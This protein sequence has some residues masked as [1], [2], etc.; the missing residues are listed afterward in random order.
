MQETARVVIL[1]L[2]LTEM[3]CGDGST[4]AGGAGG[5]TSSGGG[6]T[7]AS[8]G[9][10][11]GG[12]GGAHTPMPGTIE[13]TVEG[14]TDAGPGLVVL[15]LTKTPV[16]NAAFCE[17]VG[18]T[19]FDHTELFHP[20]ADMDPCTEDPAAQELPAGEYNLA[21]GTIVGGTM[22]FQKCAALVVTVDGDQQVT[23]PPF[24]EW[25]TPPFEAMDVCNLQ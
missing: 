17:P 21:V 23:A 22:E 16:L 19:P 25:K 14:I 11:Q 10:G 13:V 3:G 20:H 24:A 18:A 1:A 2:S 7:T 5:A 6:G 12:T 8:G 4:S 15:G 9:G